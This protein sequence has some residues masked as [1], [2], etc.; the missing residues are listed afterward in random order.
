MRFRPSLTEFLAE[1]GFS[2]CLELLGNV[3]VAVVVGNV[4]SILAMVRKV[5]DRHRERLEGIQVLMLRFPLPKHLRRQ[6][7]SWVVRETLPTLQ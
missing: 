4:L 5:S 2:T 1:Y 6:L 3:Y 7:R